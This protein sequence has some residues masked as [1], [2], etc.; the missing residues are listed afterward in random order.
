MKAVTL[1]TLNKEETLVPEYQEYL[2]N[3][4]WLDS[5]NVICDSLGNEYKE[6]KIDKEVIPIIEIT[7]A[8]QFDRLGLEVMY[9]RS[10]IAVD[11]ALMEVLRCK[12]EQELSIQYE[13]LNS[14]I[15]FLSEKCE[16]YSDKLIAFYTLPWYKRIYR[17]IKLDI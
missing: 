10:Y 13:N 14:T 1:Y 3:F 12:H 8:T 11:P 5:G 7:N 2:E 9:E 6:V 17:A 15:D 4:R 16:E